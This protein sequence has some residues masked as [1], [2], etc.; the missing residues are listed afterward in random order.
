MTPQYILVQSLYL[1]FVVSWVLNATRTCKISIIILIGK[2][3]FPSIAVNRGLNP[4][5]L[6]ILCCRLSL[7]FPNFV[8]WS[9][10]PECFEFGFQGLS[11]KDVNY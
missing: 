2:L 4:I 6:D 1:E 3:E 5:V 8:C 10:A 7:V 11:I 9:S